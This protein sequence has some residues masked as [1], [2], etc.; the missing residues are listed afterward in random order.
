[1]GIHDAPI[2]LPVL[3]ERPNLPESI[4]SVASSKPI[5]ANTF[6]EHFLIGE[7]RYVCFPRF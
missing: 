5:D 4:F 2:R 7:T 3:P 1:M 6:L